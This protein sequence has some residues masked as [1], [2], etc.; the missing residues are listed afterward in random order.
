MGLKF[1]FGKIFPCKK[2]GKLMDMEGEGC[3][4]AL[5]YMVE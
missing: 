4:A 3:G 2:I 5:L 1:I